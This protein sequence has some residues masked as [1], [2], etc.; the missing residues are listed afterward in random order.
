VH[1]VG[2]PELITGLVQ[3]RLR[4]VHAGRHQ[5]QLGAQFAVVQLEQRVAFV[6]RLIP[7][8][9]HGRDDAG[10]GSADG[11]VA[12]ARLDDAG[13]RDLVRERCLGFPRRCRLAAL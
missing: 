7:P 11:N 1:L 6:D 13:A 5:R 4:F 3:S 8:D 2:E 12:A 9:W 10:D